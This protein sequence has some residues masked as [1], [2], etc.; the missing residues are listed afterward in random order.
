MDLYDD[1]R[2]KV[3]DIVAS[4][5]RIGTASLWDFTGMSPYTSEP[6]PPPGDKVT[7]LHWFWESNHFKSALGDLVIARVFGHDAR[8]FGTRINP[9][10]LPMVEAEQRAL[11]PQYEKTHPEDLQRVVDLYIAG[12]QQACH[13]R[14]EFCQPHHPA[15]AEA[16]LFH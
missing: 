12:I 7:Q 16:A 3:T 2:R 4:A 11:F 15:H 13:L 6:I 8:G 9:E 1:W 10:N 5:A 14:A